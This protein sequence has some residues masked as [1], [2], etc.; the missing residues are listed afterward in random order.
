M[1]QDA[2]PE[3]DAQEQRAPLLA[4]DDPELPAI[5]AEVPEA[6]AYEQALPVPF[7]DEDAERR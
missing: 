2:V 5:D 1:S 3:A 7:D 6:D 4:P